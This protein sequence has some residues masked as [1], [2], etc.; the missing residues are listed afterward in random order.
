MYVYGVEHVVHNCGVACNI[1]V[2]LP[3]QG[4]M[5]WVLDEK[6]ALTSAKSP[7]TPSEYQAVCDCEVRCMYGGASC[8]VRCRS[9]T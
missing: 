1:M 6:K 8:Q 9:A 2:D 3:A 5:I 7:G 4:G